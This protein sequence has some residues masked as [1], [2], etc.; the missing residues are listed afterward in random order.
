MIPSVDYRKTV[1]IMFICHSFVYTA[2]CLYQV[3]LFSV[4]VKFWL[5]GT[6]LLLVFDG[7][8]LPRPG[9]LGAGAR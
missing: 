5:V 6:S 4:E 1:V 2:R 3:F 9:R 7:V 8:S